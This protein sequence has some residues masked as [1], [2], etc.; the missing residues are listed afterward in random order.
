MPDDRAST[1]LNEDFGQMGF[2]IP[3]VAISPWSRN[4][5]GRLAARFGAGGSTRAG[6]W[7]TAATAH[8]SILSFISYRFGLGFL[9][10][11]HQTANNIGRELQLAAIRTSIPP[12]L[13]DPPAIVTQ[14]CALGGGDV[15]DS[16]EAHAERPGRT[17]RTTPT[18]TT[19]RSTTPSRPDIFT[20]P[21][22]VK[23]AMQA[24]P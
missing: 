1:D 3:A 14:P 24:A 15:L 12:Q 5:S 20:K 8:E 11:R 18:G 9:T 23:K 10:K 2:R 4:N 7:T 22:T 21:D 6:G 19:C 17:S 16:Q 13:P